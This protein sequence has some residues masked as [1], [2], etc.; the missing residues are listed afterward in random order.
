MFLGIDFGTKRSGLAKE[1]AGIAVPA[2]GFAT[3]KMHEE[4]ERIIKSGEKIDGI[5]IGLPNHADGRESK[6]TELMRAFVAR[7]KKLFP[8]ISF[9]EQDE[10]YS[11]HFAY[12]SLAE[13]GIDRRD[14]LRVDDMAAS[15]ILQDFLD[16]KSKAL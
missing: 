5:V 16:S 12:Q 6:E 7:L 13:A 9:F 10:R 2:G 11:S 1:L 3:G 14:G 4:I 15:I 8:E